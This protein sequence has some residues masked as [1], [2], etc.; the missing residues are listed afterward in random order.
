MTER[1]KRRSNLLSHDV[2]DDLLV[3]DPLTGEAI[4]LN[5]TA[6]AIFELLDGQRTP[7]DIASAIVATVPG[8]LDIVQ[9]DV[10]KFIGQLAQLQLLEETG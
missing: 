1:P 4:L 2:E 3:Y 9:A 10:Q 8:D 6:A 7:L 5:G